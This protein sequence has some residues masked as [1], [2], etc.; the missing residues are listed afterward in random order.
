MTKSD[1]SCLKFNLHVV[2]RLQQFQKYSTNLEAFLFLGCP[3]TISRE[4]LL[5]ICLKTYQTF[6]SDTL[7]EGNMLNVLK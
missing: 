7:L 5:S 1:D 3:L 2:K 6:W 4:I